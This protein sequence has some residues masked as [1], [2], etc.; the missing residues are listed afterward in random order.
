MVA[1][2]FMYNAGE[3]PEYEDLYKELDQYLA[4]AL[5]EV[6]KEADAFG[7]EFA[8]RHKDDKIHYFVG[9]G[10]QYGATYS[11]AMCYW[12]EQTLDSY[13]IYPQCRIFPWNVR[14]N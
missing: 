3:F 5:V 13:K 2:R 1:D 12:E 8:N 11:Y 7:E 9:A 14:N 6:E 4:T 10:N